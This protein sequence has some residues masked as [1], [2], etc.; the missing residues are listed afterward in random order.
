MY[1]EPPS[2]NQVSL[3]A[4]SRALAVRIGYK[5]GLS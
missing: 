4:A 2:N 5:W 3:D 1:S